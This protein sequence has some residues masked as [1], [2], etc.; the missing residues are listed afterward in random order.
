MDKSIYKNKKILD[1]GYGDGRNLIFF[2]DL[3]MKVFGIEPFQ[4]V[5]SY[6]KKIF[7][8]ANL[9]Q[10][11]NRQIPY[12]NEEFDYLVASHSIYYL[13][14]GQ[15]LLENLNEA[16]RVLKSQGNMFFTIPTPHNHYIQNAEK[17]SS[18][19]WKIRDEFYNVRYG[20][21]I[22]TINTKDQLNHLLNKLPIKVHNIGFWD[23]DWWGTKE[24]SYIISAVKN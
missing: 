7:P 15:T 18:N 5:V 2:K 12:D 1:L 17:I 13:D 9:K 4:E 20:Q 11:K 24:S 14:E 10:G 6:S 8:W 3:G 22:D 21:I 23:V 16:F 19:Q